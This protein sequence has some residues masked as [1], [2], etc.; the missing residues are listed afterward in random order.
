[1]N[2]KL[3]TA[4]SKVFMLEFWQL[5]Q[6]YL[7]IKSPFIMLS[8]AQRSIQ[9]DYCCRQKDNW[10]VCLIYEFYHWTHPCRIL[11]YQ[12]RHLSER[13]RLFSWQFKFF[14]KYLEAWWHIYALVN[15]DIFGSGDGLSPGPW[16]NIKMPSYQYRKSHC[17]DKTVVRS[18]Y[19][20]NGIS[21]TG[22]LP[23]LYWIG[24]LVSCH[25]RNQYWFWGN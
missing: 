25:L 17:G 4:K 22:K 2:I 7:L 13:K 19:L 9:H 14:I 5:S 24:A 12:A 21:Y 3:R 20:N 8:T 6:F 10:M 1:M 15:S 16:F 11:L 18:S 23:S